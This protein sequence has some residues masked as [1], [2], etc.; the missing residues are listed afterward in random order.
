MPEVSESCT[1]ERPARVERMVRGMV[2][3][4]A[5]SA[6]HFS[7]LDAEIGDGDHGNNFSRGVDAAAAAVDRR[8]PQTWT[9]FCL[10]AGDS[11]LDASGGAS[12]ALYGTL[13]RTMGDKMALGLSPT[14][15][16]GEAVEALAR[17]GKAKVGDKTMLDVLVPVANALNEGSPMSQALAL[18]RHRLEQTRSLRARRGR[19]SF[20]GERSVGHLDPGAA[21]SCAALEVILMAVEFV[22]GT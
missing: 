8:R 2:A 18:A 22:D 13:I 20:L 19:A 9:D 12:G 3:L 15:A 4:A 7:E 21:S 14:A 16:F 6:R 10:I 1:A 11:W 5:G 17:L